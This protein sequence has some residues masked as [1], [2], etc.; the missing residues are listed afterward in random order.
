[1]SNKLPR[2]DKNLGQH[3]LINQEVIESITNDFKDQASGILEVGPGP[4]ILTEFLAKHEL[5]F[6]VIE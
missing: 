4:G 5:P 3:F 2:A 6:Y 1:M